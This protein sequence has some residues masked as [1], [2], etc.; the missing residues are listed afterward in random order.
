[1]NKNL[2][3]FV[4]FFLKYSCNQQIFCNFAGQMCLSIKVHNQLLDLS[5]P[6]VMAIVNIT[7][8][9]FYTA[10]GQL[11]ED[12]LLAQVQSA[13][14]QGARILDI[15]A[16]STR[17]DSTPVDE[18]T[19]WLRLQ[20]ALQAIRTHFPTIAL[21]VDTF[22]ANIAQQALELGA[23]IINDISGGADKRMW[24]VV[25][26]HHAPYI[27]TYAQEIPAASA[28]YDNTMS[29]ILDF[30]QKRLN[31]LH[32]MGIADVILDPG[33]GFCKTLEQN[34]TIL[35]Q[36]DI[37]SVLHAP[38]LVGISRKSMLYKP[39]DATPADV[40]AATTAAHTIALERGAHI[41]RVHDVAAAQQTIKVF[42]LTHHSCCTL[43]GSN[44]CLT[45]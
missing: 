33:F 10:W 3:F 36:L 32:R 9:S 41:L 13:I 37:L 11:S 29:C 22:R 15:G 23:D 25:A 42:Q 38:I 8:D 30:F 1:M 35:R 19:E 2:H 31:N 17:P 44:D 12:A 16:C 6:Q 34:Y 28:N 14:N 21:S 20:P 5:S 45:D 26:N 7:P 40:L 39:L 4:L 24:E 18:H 43:K 27:L